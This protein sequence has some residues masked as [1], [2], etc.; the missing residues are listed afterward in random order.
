MARRRYRGED[1]W[2]RDFFD[3][4]FED[5]DIDIRKMNERMAKMFE[6]L[7]S[8][9]DT[10]TFG[11]FVYGFSYKMGKD[12]KPTFQEFGNVPEMMQRKPEI[13]VQ[14]GTREPLVDLN[15][16]H[17]KYYVTYELPGIEKK[18]IDLKVTENSIVLNA[19]DDQRN[20]YKKIEFQES[21]ESDSASA[22]FVNGILD[23]S[24]SKLSK[25]EKEGK[26]IKID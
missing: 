1:D 14:K 15:E 3:D 21:V 7:K 16:D 25:K 12:G 4:F 9:P 20:Y 13:G 10:E 22:K 24:I 8:S 11:P 18:D 2:D 6:E 17:D 23:V 19:K 26:N 5:F